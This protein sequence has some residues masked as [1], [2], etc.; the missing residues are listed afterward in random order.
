VGE[1]EGEDTNLVIKPLRVFHDV[2]F[3]KKTPYGTKK[4]YAS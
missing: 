1:I 3:T 4:N 2:L